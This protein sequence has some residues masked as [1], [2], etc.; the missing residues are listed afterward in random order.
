[1]VLESTFMIVICL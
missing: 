1:M